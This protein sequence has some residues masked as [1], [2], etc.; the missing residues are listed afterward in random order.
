MCSSRYICLCSSYSRRTFGEASRE[1][2]GRETVSGIPLGWGYLPGCRS[3]AS[4]VSS[5]RLRV[6]ICDTV[7]ANDVCFMELLL[8]LR[9]KPCRASHGTPCMEQEVLK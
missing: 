9:R 6:L 7:S 1:E 3:W 4:Y 2:E 8:N 5:G